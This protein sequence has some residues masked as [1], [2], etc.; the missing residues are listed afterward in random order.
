MINA[1]IQ[2]TTTRR[3]DRQRLIESTRNECIGELIRD[4]ATAVV[5]NRFDL[6]S[7]Y[8][9][10]IRSLL[11]TQ[12][13]DGGGGVDVRGDVG[14]AALIEGDVLYAPDFIAVPINV[15]SLAVLQSFGLGSVGGGITI[16]GVRYLNIPPGDE[17]NYNGNH[18]GLYQQ[19]PREGNDNNRLLLLAAYLPKHPIQQ[20][21][22]DAIGVDYVGRCVSVKLGQAVRRAQ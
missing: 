12:Q 13:R 14:L 15:E 4:V 20:I 9:D 19:L 8:L 17:G 7:E 18:A 3:I 22:R 6:R 21:V 5:D 11:L 2:R 1:T 10:E 16:D